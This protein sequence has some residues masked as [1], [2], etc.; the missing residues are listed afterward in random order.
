MILLIGAVR[1]KKPFEKERS[2]R[3]PTLRS[4]TI[5]AL[6]TG[7]LCLS[8][9]SSA[10]EPSG[11]FDKNSL[12]TGQK[13]TWKG[14]VTEHGTVHLASEQDT[15]GNSVTFVADLKAKCKETTLPAKGKEVTVQGI[16]ENIDMSGTDYQY[17]A[18]G[19][20]TTATT[21]YLVLKDCRVY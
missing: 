9:C 13:Y 6:A 19:S 20:R 11:G 14:T 3:K 5:V 18:D 4:S 21:R 17:K 12:L 2:M 10:S 16:L 7:L 8:S 15:L 1:R